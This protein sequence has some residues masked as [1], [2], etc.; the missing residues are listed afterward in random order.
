MKLFRILCM[1]FS[2][3]LLTATVAP[4]D[5]FAK[6]KGKKTKKAFKKLKKAGKKFRKKRKKAFKRIRKYL[7][8]QGIEKGSV[9]GSGLFK[10]EDY[11]GICAL[12]ESAE[13]DCPKKLKKLHK[14]IVKGRKKLGKKR[15]KF[16]KKK[17]KAEASGDVEEEEVA[18]M[19]AELVEL[20]EDVEGD[21]EEEDLE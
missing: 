21:S 3:T 2:F 16:K 5:A 11:D 1:L 10:A 12:S 18:E 14:K 19:D 17:E 4:V 20:E 6:G 8:K 13:E 15:D 7:K 9:K